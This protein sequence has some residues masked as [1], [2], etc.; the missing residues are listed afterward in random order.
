MKICGIV[1]GEQTSFVSVTEVHVT[2]L[3]KMTPW[4]CGLE[5]GTVVAW[6]RSAI[7]LFMAILSQRERR[8]S[9]D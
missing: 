8:I 1:K 5:A 7:E 3:W 6:K 4:N 9:L 2:E